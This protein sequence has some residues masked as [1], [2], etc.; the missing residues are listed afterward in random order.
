LCLPHE[1]KR[2]DVIRTKVFE[3][4][5]RDNVANWF[6]W[7]QRNGL[8]VG[9]ME[10]LILVTGCTMAASWAAAAFFHPTMDGKVSLAVRNYDNGGISFHWSN[11]HGTVRRH[12]SSSDPVRAFG[13]NHST[14]TNLSFVVLK[15]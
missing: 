7:S 2:K 5:I 8:G 6:A 10:D 4:Y 1:A 14:Y 11:V 13:C 9:R 15:A 3:D 12:N